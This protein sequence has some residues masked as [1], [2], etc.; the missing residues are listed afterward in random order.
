M[1]R[2]RRS[3]A[4]PTRARLAALAKR[5][6]PT[7]ATG[8]LVLAARWGQSDVFAGADGGG[9]QDRPGRRSPSPARSAADRADAARRLIRLRDDA[10]DDQADPRAGHAAGVDASCRAVADPVAGRQPRRRRRR[11]SS[12]R[13]WS[14]PH[15]RRRAPPPS[16]SCSAASP[17]TRALLEGDRGQEARAQRP[18]P[19]PTGRSSSR[20]AS[21]TSRPSRASST[22][23]TTNADRLKVL[24]AMLPAAGDEGR[25]RR[26][27]RSCTRQLCAQCHAFNGAGR[28]ARPGAHRHRRRAT[29]RRSSPRSSTPTARSR[30]TTACGT[31][32]PSA[33]DQLLRPARRR[34]A[35]DRRAARRH[36]PAPR[37]P[38]R[39]TSAR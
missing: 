28:Q 33:G 4:T 13:S 38:A 1:T 16:A 39:R 24:E 2:P 29:R 3:S 5:C 34:D 8:S 36:R 11:R 14:T 10:G 22:R 35:D 18:R 12:S 26:R 19:R 20:T 15:A 32:R 30:P 9:A 6:P 21:A 17:W 31:S 37:H 23:R 25:R 27:A 7:S